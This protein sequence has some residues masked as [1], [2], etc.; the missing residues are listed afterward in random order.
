[1]NIS[2]KAKLISGFSLIIILT[3]VIFFIANLTISNFNQNFN[4]IIDREVER[5]MLSQRSAELIQLITKREKDFLLSESLDEKED[6]TKEIEGYG[7]ELESKIRELADIS[8]KRGLAILEDFDKSWNTYIETFQT[9]RQIGMDL[10][11]DAQDRATVISTTIARQ[12]AFGAIDNMNKLVEKNT[13]AL[14]KARIESNDQA[15]STN[16][17]MIGLLLISIAISVG[18]SFWII[19]SIMTSLGQAR[20]VIKAVSEGDLTIKISNYTKDEIGQLVE[21]IEAMT[22]RLIDTISAITISANSIMLASNEMSKTAQNLADGTQIQASSAEEIS[23][24]MEQMVSNIQQNTSNA[25]ETKG[26]ATQASNEIE[27][28]MDS[29]RTTVESMKQITDKIAV[30]GEIARQ[31]NLLALNAA[32]EAARA[33]DHGKGFAVVAAEIRK[34]AENSQNAAAEIDELS[35]KG[36][37]HADNSLKLIEQIVP[38]ILQT[39]KLVEGISSASIEQNSGAEQINNSIQ[40]FN[41]VIQQNASGADQLASSSQELNAQSEELRANISQF[42][43]GSVLVP[44]TELNNG[45]KEVLAKAS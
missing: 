15:S 24:S 21:M 45:L 32:V 28:G 20:K 22:T 10:S 35:S 34:L 30:I 44:K 13:N 12:A 42:K 14:E 2:I 36:V 16:L 6:Y 39:S 7:S 8:D 1:M 29:V 3:G 37:N 26:I 23:A 41:H 33:G 17:F 5:I 40:S 25:Q 4:T 19:R 11:D 27:L 18:V 31:T 9:I 38:G 43:T